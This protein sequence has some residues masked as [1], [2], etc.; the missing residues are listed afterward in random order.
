MNPGEPV[1]TTQAHGRVWPV[2]EKPAF[3]LEVTGVLEFETRN[4]AIGVETTLRDALRNYPVEIKLVPVTVLLMSP[5]DQ[6]EK[7]RLD[8][9]SLN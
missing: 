7:D 6:A 9:E 3:S 5:E 8:Q 4:E 2:Y 1:G